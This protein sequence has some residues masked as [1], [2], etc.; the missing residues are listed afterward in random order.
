MRLPAVLLL[1]TS[2]NVSL[3]SAASLRGVDPALTAR[4]Q[5]SSGKFTCFDRSRSLPVA[6]VN[7]NFCDCLDGSDEPGEALSWTAVADRCWRQL[8]IARAPKMYCLKRTHSSQLSA[9][10]CAGSS[11]CANGIFYCRNRGH[12][13]LRLNSSLV[14]DGVCGAQT[15]REAAPAW[16]AHGAAGLQGRLHAEPGLAC[17]LLRR[18]GRAPG[19]LQEHVP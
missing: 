3:G 14:D 2:L 9:A 11:A 10:R 18:L 4:Y 15:W 19:P 13:P 1:A 6:Q 5:P 7:D 16:Q 12:E 17:R 8:T